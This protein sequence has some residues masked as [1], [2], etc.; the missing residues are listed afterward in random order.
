MASRTRV[1]DQGR[2]RCRRLLERR[3]RA[4]REKIAQVEE[5]L[6]RL[7]EE[8][9]VKTEEVIK[10]HHEALRGASTGEPTPSPDHVFAE[11][12]SL[13]LLK[14]VLEREAE[15]VEQALARREV[16]HPRESVFTRAAKRRKIARITL[17][18]AEAW[19]EEDWEEIERD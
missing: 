12:L 6:K 2:T 8:Y 1:R 3:L 18:E 7:E 4:L 10:Q 19:A 14:N 13:A 15:K 9:G 5:G 11:W 17:G 16:G